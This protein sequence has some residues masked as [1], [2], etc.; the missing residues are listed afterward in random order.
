MNLIDIIIPFT[1][2]LFIVAVGVV[3]LYQNFQKNLMALELEKVAIEAKRRDELLN[4]SIMVQEEERKR[5]AQ[6]LHDDLGAVISI[7]RMNLKLMSQKQ[8]TVDMNGAP[9]GSIQNMISLSETAMASLRNISHQLMPPQ[10]EAFGIVKSIE[11]VV[12]QI[13]QSGV[14]MVHFVLKCEWPFI[15]WPVAL[16][17]YRII[18]ELTNNTIKHAHAHNIFLEFNYL[19]SYLIINFNDDGIGFPDI[20]NIERGLGLTSMEAR[21]RAMNGRFDCHN[22]P[23]GGVEAILTIPYE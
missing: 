14:I 21:A 5:I 3:F 9:I 16:G 11:S 23:E 12:G 2:T 1:V 20:L 19:N 13:N 4:N 15:K 22:G 17:I 7:L 6:D 10:L 18:M 8:D